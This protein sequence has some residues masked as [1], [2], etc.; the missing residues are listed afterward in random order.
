[1]RLLCILLKNTL[2]YFV[3]LVKFGTGKKKKKNNKRK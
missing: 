2:S 1:M 3:D